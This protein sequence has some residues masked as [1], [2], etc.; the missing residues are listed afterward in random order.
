MKKKVLIIIITAGICAGLI[1]TSMSYLSM[2]NSKIS[3]QNKIS[4]YTDSA[5]TSSSENLSHILNAQSQESNVDTE[6]FKDPDDSSID[7]LISDD[8]FITQLDYIITN[9][10]DFIGKRIKVQGILTTIENNRFIVVRLYDMA[11]EDHS[12]EITVGINAEYDGEIPPE[13]TWV[14]ITGII[15]KSQIDSRILP[16]VD[17]EKI[18]TY[19]TYGQEKVYN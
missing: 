15:K 5:L 4:S 18:Q 16:I 12:H 14:S 13:S 10:D 1:K 3:H 17:V 9:I 2:Y 7:I 11:H 6:S 19:D 8:T